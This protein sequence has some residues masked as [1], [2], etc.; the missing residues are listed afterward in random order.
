MIRLPWE[1]KSIKYDAET[2]DNPS[3]LPNKPIEYHF[4]I[5]VNDEKLYNPKPLILTTTFNI[6]AQKKSGAS[7]IDGK[8]IILTSAEDKKYKAKTKDGKVVFKDVALG[9]Y[10][11]K[12]AN[13]S[14][15][16]A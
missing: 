9:K 6:K 7:M 5:S 10:S 4:T 3:E 13:V 8:T 16:E 12:V 1:V 2:S 11:L 15:E 14:E